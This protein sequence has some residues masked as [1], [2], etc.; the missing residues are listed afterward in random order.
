[1]RRI[2]STTR[3]VAILFIVWSVMMAIGAAVAQEEDVVVIPITVVRGDPGSIHLIDPPGVVPVA[4][5]RVGLTCLVAAEA[6]NQGSVHPNTDLIVTSGGSSVVIPDVEREAGGL[7]FGEGFLTLGETAMIEVRLGADGV[8]SGG[9]AVGLC[10]EIIE[11]CG[12]PALSIGVAPGDQEVVAGGDANFDVTVTNTGDEPFLSV[13]V[14]S[15]I[16]ACDG[17]IGAMALG[18]QSS[19]TCTAT[20]VTEDLAATFAAAGTGQDPTCAATA[21]AGAAVTVLQAC[22]SNPALTITV[23]PGDQDVPDGGDADFQVTVTNTGDE[24]MV[25]VAVDSSVAACDNTIGALAVGAETSYACK[26]VGVET[27]LNVSF[28]VTGEGVTQGALCSASDDA[29]A[30]VGNPPPP[31]TTT[32]TTTTPRTPTGVPTGTGG[33]GSSSVP[34]GALAVAGL[35]LAVIGA[36][37]YRVTRR[38]H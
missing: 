13:N 14:D 19:Y 26:A 8:F 36:G 11:T 10:R 18:A 25:G 1:M 17:S 34:V 12:D 3:G 22:N 9:F 21:N 29:A 32:T 4:A 7:I 24:D 30:R 6:A 5:D 28:A 15:S 16:A 20:G 2:R 35:G 37:T 23:V 31:T 38:E 27:D 33:S